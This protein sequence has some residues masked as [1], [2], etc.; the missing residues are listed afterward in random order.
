MLYFFR[1]AHDINLDPDSPSPSKSLDP[2]DCFGVAID[3]DHLQP[4]LNDNKC[5]SDDDPCCPHVP[6]VTLPIEPVFPPSPEP[7]SIPNPFCGAPSP[8]HKPAL[9]SENSS[10]ANSP[11]RK[12]D[13]QGSPVKIST[14]KKNR[15]NLQNKTDFIANNNHFLN[16]PSRSVTDP[17]NNNNLNI[18]ITSPFCSPRRIR[19]ISVGEEIVDAFVRSCSSP[20]CGSQ[21][22]RS[23]S[24]EESSP[25][26]SVNS[27][28][29]EELLENYE[30]DEVTFEPV[31]NI[32]EN[33][34]DYEVDDVIEVDEVLTVEIKENLP[35]VTEEAAKN[36]TA[37]SSLKSISIE[38]TLEEEEEIEEQETQRDGVTQN[39]GKTEHKVP[40]GF[41]DKEENTRKELKEEKGKSEGGSTVK[42]RRL[43][44]EI[45]KNKKCK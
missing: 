45:P 29:R 13:F 6:R 7:E 4:P 44:P 39:R 30:V 25:S 27:I 14:P 37:D 34:Y 31:D 32:D 18:N 8:R 5:C 16:T 35:D 38:S 42:R 17:S 2:A 20:I 33:D 11:K 9:R 36:E 1:L 21:R 28:D 3:D 15:T 41:T 23:A 12:V 26:D 43:L 24:L 40:N 10:I 19:Q 22:P